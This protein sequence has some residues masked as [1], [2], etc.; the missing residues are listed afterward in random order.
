MTKIRF[1]GFPENSEVSISASQGG[2][3]KGPVSVSAWRQAPVAEPKGPAEMTIEVWGHNNGTPAPASIWFEASITGDTG[4]SPPINGFLPDASGAYT[5]PLATA[6]YD[7]YDQQ[8]H[9][10]EFEWSFGDTGVW[11]YADRLPTQLQQRDYGHGK[12]INHVYSTPGDKT[13]TCTAYRMGVDGSGNLTRTLVA[14]KTITFADGG[15]YPAIPT[16]EEYFPK[17]RI[18]YWSPDGDYSDVP[19]GA[20]TGSNIGQPGLWGAIKWVADRAPDPACI[21]IR[22]GTTA[23]MPDD[24]AFRM[25]NPKA[26]FGAYGTGDR[27][28]ISRPFGGP[29]FGAPIHSQSAPGFLIVNGIEAVGSWDAVNET[30]SASTNAAQ[31]MLGGE[32]RCHVLAYD[33]IFRGSSGT[34][35][36]V[37]QLQNRGTQKKERSYTICDTLVTGW[38]DY[39]IMVRGNCTEAFRQDLSV[40]GSRVAQL[41][42]AAQGAAG[43]E[44]LQNQHGP[45]RASMVQ[46]LCV[47]ASDIFS[48]THWDPNVQSCIRMHT[49]SALQF[50]ETPG[51]TMIY[52]NSIEG[53]ANVIISGSG[54]GQDALAPFSKPL[55][56]GYQLR[57][58]SFPVD[59]VVKHNLFLGCW[60]VDRAVNIVR[61]PTSIVENV[62]IRPDV[63][64]WNVTQADLDRGPVFSSSV[65][66]VTELEGETGWIPGWNDEVVRQ[67]ARVIGNLTIDLKNTTRTSDEITAENSA[68]VAVQLQGY[69]EDRDNTLFAPNYAFAPVTDT[70]P[71]VYVQDIPPR[72]TYGLRF[73]AQVKEGALTDA[74]KDEFGVALNNIWL[75][76][77]YDEDPS[78]ATPADGL[79]LYRP[80][81]G[82][83]VAGAAT[84][85]MSHRDF[86][87]TVRTAGVPASAGAIEPA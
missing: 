61:T 29:F 21:L 10:L 28:V 77:I 53:G 87:G 58:H 20:F 6:E 64:R 73:D 3:T 69:R 85:P 66:E 15:D 44:G 4:L 31:A 47:R 12:V 42:N 48:R 23:S 16:I 62:A 81:I 13:V 70:G 45:I 63:L 34:N 51:L 75:D 79:K 71:W 67:P 9:E 68:F 59:I 43:K 25:E 24:G 76:G 5:V 57:V 1:S 80:A 50:G 14:S 65:S 40:L 82:A 7:H 18:L 30:D 41:P 78:Y 56:E 35:V 74:M 2:V 22:R 52:G 17:N 27:P 39:G 32:G 46:N 49:R 60:S 72:E 83:A 26:Y 8:F 86:W 19:P 37:S 38:R 33:C 36:V 54:G 55:P 84:G 11:K